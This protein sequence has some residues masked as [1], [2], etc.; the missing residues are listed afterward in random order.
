MTI[1]TKF[2]YNNTIYFTDKGNFLKGNVTGIVLYHNDDKTDTYYTILDT[3]NDEHYSIPEC[4]TYHTKEEIIEKINI[5]L[6][7]L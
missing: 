1:Q 2:D 6:K 7:D 3:N 5:Q 4:D